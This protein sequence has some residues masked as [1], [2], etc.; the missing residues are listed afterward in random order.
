[1]RSTD[2]KLGLFDSVHLLVGAMIGSAI[3]SLSG[4]TILQAGPAS[5]LSWILGGVILLAY[6]LQ[7]AELA[8]R[9]PQSG[10]VFAFPAIVLGKTREQGRVWGWVSAWAYLFGCVAGAAFSA[11]YIGI[12]LG[13]AFPRLASLQV[14]IAIIS[15]L[16]CGYLNLV[17]FKIT[18]RA[19]TILTIFLVLA[20]LVFALSVFVSG[21]WDTTLFTPFFTQGSGGATGFLD[22]L[23]LAMVAYGAIVSLS[24]LVGEVHNPVRNIPRAMTIAMVIVLVFYLSVLVATLGVVSSS[25]LAD[26]PDLQY[27][28]LYAAA[29]L[30]PSLTFLPP[31]I[32]IAAVLALVT[33]MIVTMAL[34]SHTVCTCSENGVL[35][36]SLGKTGNEWRPRRSHH[37]HHGDHRGIR[38]VPPADRHIDQLRGAVQRHC[39]RHRLHHRHGITKTRAHAFDGYIPR[40]RRYRASHHHPSGSGRF[41]RSQHSAGRLEALGRH[42]PVLRARNAPVREAEAPVMKIAYGV[43]DGV[44]QGHQAVLKAH[45]DVVYVLPPVGKPVLTTNEEKQELLATYAP[46]HCD[47]RFVSTIPSGEQDTPISVSPVLYDGQPITSERI[48]DALKDGKMEDALAMLGHPY[49]MHGVVVY[50]KQ[51]GRTVGMPT[52][53]L[54]CATEKLVPC[55][56]V[57]GSVTIVDGK[58]YLGV[59]S[60]GLRPTVDDRPDVTIETFLIHFNQEL[61]GQHIALEV[62]TYL[63]P[64]TKF[65]DLAAVR[66]QVDDDVRLFVSYSIERHLI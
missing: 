50:G 54:Q 62:V 35:P 17:R 13:V 6:G 34:A 59:T 41:L 24:F 3:F 37:R 9:Y 40:P 4:I 1:M 57:Y 66:R 42:R 52:V 15:V 61:Y 33:T 28:P 30:L 49:T 53:N 48:K 38:R 47:I 44:H 45:P 20:L 26:H 7:T 29:A 2:G 8:S 18:S 16:L 51:L 36:V 55:H 60:I 11:I 58:R 12:Y 25:Y 22:A 39:R 65:P 31:L 21:K 32:S 63:R 56:G 64:I 19:T 43:F 5:I 10:G 27:T 23:P 46:S 14:P